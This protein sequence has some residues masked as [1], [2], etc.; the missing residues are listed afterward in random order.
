MT[1]SKCLRTEGPLPPVLWLMSSRLT[2][3]GL[4]MKDLQR[5][6][7]DLAEEGG[8]SRRGLAGIGQARTWLAGC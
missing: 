2:P 8:G 3:T 5:G 7:L 1:S 4:L 6:W